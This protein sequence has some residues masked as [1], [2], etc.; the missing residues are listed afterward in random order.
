MP[1]KKVIIS[2]DEI[3][4]LNSI[5]YINQ[6]CSDI[7]SSKTI[8]YKILLIVERDLQKICNDS[9]FILSD[10]IKNDVDYYD[11][12]KSQTPKELLINLSFISSENHLKENGLNLGE[13]L[14]KDELFYIHKIVYMILLKSFFLNDSII[15][16]MVNKYEDE[17]TWRL[18]N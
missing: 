7:D 6:N 3:K 10:A 9:L 11:L 8:G 5:E 13:N 12:L 15:E 2:K 16:N 17:E 1:A 14:S 18:K 4:I